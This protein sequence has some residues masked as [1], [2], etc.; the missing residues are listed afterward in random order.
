MIVIKEGIE[1]SGL[2]EMIGCLL[3]ENGVSG[4]K[5]KCFVL[6]DIYPDD[7]IFKMIF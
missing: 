7:Y 1:S 5:Y 4:I 3:I 6:L 2:G